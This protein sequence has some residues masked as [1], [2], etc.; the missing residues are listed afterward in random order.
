M[1]TCKNPKLAA[2]SD[3]SAELKGLLSAE[4]VVISSFGDALVRRGFTD[5]AGLSNAVD[6]SLTAVQKAAHLFSMISMRVEHDP[7]TYC[8]A[9]IDVL[10]EFE[11]LESLADKV[12][13]YLQEHESNTTRT[14]SITSATSATSA[15]TTTS[16]TNASSATSNTSN[17]SA[18]SVTSDTS[19][20]ST[21]S[22]TKF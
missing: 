13:S 10:N 6:K 9:Y 2:V 8:K 1:S 20:T 11:P 4:N 19:A 15:T 7:E 12:L 3:S 21:T 16:T 22:A 14:T 17:T 5:R 18:T